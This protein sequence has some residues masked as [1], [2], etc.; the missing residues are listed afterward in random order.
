[1]GEEDLLEAFITHIKKMRHA[2]V[3]EVFPFVKDTLL[4]ADVVGVYFYT[5]F[6]KH[7]L[8][9]PVSRWTVHRWMIT[10]GCTHHRAQTHLLH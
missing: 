1:M 8:K 7:G 4:R 5:L 6:K 10:S 3:D 2:T 9:I